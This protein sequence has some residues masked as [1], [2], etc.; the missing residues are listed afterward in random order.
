MRINRTICGCG[1]GRDTKY[2]IDQGYE[3]TAIDGS[4]ELCK[5]A[6][7]LT[8]IEVNNMLFQDIEYVNEF[9]GVWACASL[10]HVPKTELLSVIKRITR[11]LKDC[12]IFF[13]SFKYGE[14]EGER[15]GRFFTDLN[16]DSFVKI[17]SEVPELVIQEKSIATD[18][19]PG[20][21]ESWLNAILVKH[22]KQELKTRDELVEREQPERVEGELVMDKAGKK[23]LRINS[24]TVNIADLRTVIMNIIEYIT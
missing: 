1:S 7:E 23:Y 3:V 21:D 13:V 19:R 10:L 5:R 14:Y 4:K 22:E 8:G 16:E 20:R 24:D 18:V 9:D 12:G 17:I 2:F 11:A 15:N 6:S